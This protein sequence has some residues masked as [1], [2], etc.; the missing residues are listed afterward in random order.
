MHSFR[1]IKWVLNSYWKHRQNTKLVTARKARP[2]RSGFKRTPSIGGHARLNP[3]R[4][5]YVSMLHNA[6]PAMNTARDQVARESK[7]MIGSRTRSLIRK[8]DRYPLSPISGEQ[9]CEMDR[10]SQANKRLWRHSSP[11]EVERKERTSATHRVRV[12][13][14]RT[15]TRAVSGSVRTS[16]GAVRRSRQGAPRGAVLRKHWLALRRT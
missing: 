3:F 9:R 16:A 5:V 11:S 14:A 8:A 1:S 7:E 13:P 15:P 10:N 2:L 6:P 12:S 4:A